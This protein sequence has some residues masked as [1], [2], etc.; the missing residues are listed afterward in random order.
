MPDGGDVFAN[1]HCFEV[2]LRK[3]IPFSF[4]V[5]VPPELNELFPNGASARSSF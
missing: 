2:L 1:G 4:G 3:A 5:K